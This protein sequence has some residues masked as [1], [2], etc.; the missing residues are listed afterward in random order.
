MSSVNRR[1]VLKRAALGALAYTVGGA[2]VLLS[3]RTADYMARNWGA[4]A[5]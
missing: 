2:E 5:A 4:I 3:P 1:M